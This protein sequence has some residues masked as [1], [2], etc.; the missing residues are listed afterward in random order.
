MA[1]KRNGFGRLNKRPRA[2]KNGKNRGPAWIPFM[3]TP[4]TDFWKRALVDRGLRKA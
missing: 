2:R 4:S 1:R 3:S